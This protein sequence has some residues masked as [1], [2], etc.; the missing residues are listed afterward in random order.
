[1]PV[2]HL[3]ICGPCNDQTR[4]AP[5]SLVCRIGTDTDPD[6][7]RENLQHGAG[8]MPGEAVR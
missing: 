5:C 8:T 2:K 7:W 4:F 3:R 6:S 1:M